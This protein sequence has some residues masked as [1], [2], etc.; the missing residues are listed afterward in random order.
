MLVLVCVCVCDC[1]CVCVCVC[2]CVR[3]S[4]TFSADEAI[5]SEFAHKLHL[6]LR[7]MPNIPQSATKKNIHTHAQTHRQTGR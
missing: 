3:E 1:V 4:E 7:F 2:T 6:N 5:T